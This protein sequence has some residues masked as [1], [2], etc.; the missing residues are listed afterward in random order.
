MLPFCFDRFREL[1]V[2]EEMKKYETG[3]FG[4]KPGR[5]EDAAKGARMSR[6]VS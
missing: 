1:G 3:L 6:R 4:G 2:L 5:W